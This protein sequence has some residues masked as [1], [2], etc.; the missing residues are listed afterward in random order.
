M[1]DCFVCPITVDTEKFERLIHRTEG[2]SRQSVRFVFADCGLW[3]VDCDC[4]ILTK[5]LT[6]TVLR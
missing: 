6:T 1:I 4:V 2:A 5:Y 3:I